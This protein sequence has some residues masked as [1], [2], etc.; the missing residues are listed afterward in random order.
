MATTE[1]ALTFELRTLN[2]LRRRLMTINGSLFA[3]RNEIQN[4]YTLFPPW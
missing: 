4:P 3:L 1:N 2:D